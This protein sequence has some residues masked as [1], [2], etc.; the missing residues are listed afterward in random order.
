MPVRTSVADNSLEGAVTTRQKQPGMTSMLINI[1]HTKNIH[2]PFR[3]SLQDSRS[4][5]LSRFFC[6]LSVLLLYP[7]V[8]GMGLSKRRKRGSWLVAWA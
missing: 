2:S 5:S 4:L 7:A 6:E 8:G 1:A 3:Q